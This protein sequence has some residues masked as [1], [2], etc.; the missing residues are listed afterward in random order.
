MLHEIGHVEGFSPL[1]VGFE[2]YVQYIGGSQVFVGPGVTAA[3]VDSDQE[4]D[5]SRYP[6]DVMSATLAPGVRELPSALDVQILNVVNTLSSPPAPGAGTSATSVPTASTVVAPTTVVDHAIA[7]LGS[8]VLPIVSGPAALTSPIK[9]APVN[10]KPANHHKGHSVKLKT[11]HTVKA[12]ASK[13]PTHQVVTPAHHKANK[14]SGS[15]TPNASLAAHL[16]R[17][18]VRAIGDSHPSGPLSRFPDAMHTG[19]EATNGDYRQNLLGTRDRKLSDI[20]NLDS[21]S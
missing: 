4:L 8:T 12:H 11:K 21:L 17:R 5:P 19:P 14:K 3:L 15:P 6:G 16:S 20:L 2:R 13:A 1:N 18:G 10:G 7:A 9:G